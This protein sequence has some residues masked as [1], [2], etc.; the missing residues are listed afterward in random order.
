MQFL[1]RVWKFTFKPSNLL[2]VLRRFDVGRELTN[3][4]RLRGVIPSEWC[5][6]DGPVTG[7][8]PVS[9]LLSLTPLIVCYWHKADLPNAHSNVRIC[10]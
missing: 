1:P 8:N 4:H 10:G 2:I 9:E 3:Q 7:P 6:G 5:D